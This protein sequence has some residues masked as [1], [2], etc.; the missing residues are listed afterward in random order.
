[1]QEKKTLSTHATEAVPPPYPVALG[2]VGTALVGGNGPPEGDVGGGQGGS[3][4]A[5]EGDAQGGAL[6]ALAGVPRLP[7]RVGEMR[8]GLA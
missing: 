6:V 1:M 4:S 2:A 7:V 5:K 8:E 3:V